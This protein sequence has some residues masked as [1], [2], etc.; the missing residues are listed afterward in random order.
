MVNQKLY[1]CRWGVTIVRV[2][3]RLLWH[4]N[5]RSCMHACMYQVGLFF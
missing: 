4:V 3:R 1:P 5:L 2:L